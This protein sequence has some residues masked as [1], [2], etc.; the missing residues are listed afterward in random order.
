MRVFRQ[1]YTD[2][3]GKTRESSKWYVE[4]KD[5][6]ERLRRLP[7]FTDKAATVELGKRVERLV[8][9]RVMRDE[10][11]PELARWLETIPNDLRKRLGKIGL[12]DAKTIAGKKPLA[13]HVD[14]FVTSLRS[15]GLSDDYVDP[16][17]A[18]IRRLVELCGFQSI[19]DISGATVQIALAKLKVNGS[20]GT[21]KDDG[22]VKTSRGLGQRTLN[23]YLAATK[24]FTRW[25]VTEGRTLK[26]ALA[27]LKAGNANLDIRRERRELSETELQALLK[28]AVAG[29]TLFGIAGQNRR[30]LYL[31]A[32]ST[33][34]RASECA[35]LTPRHFDLNTDPP[36]VRIDAADEKSRRGDVLPIPSDLVTML[37]PWLATIGPNE[38]LWPGDWAQKRRGSKMMMADLARAGI[39]YRDDDGQQADFHALR[40]TFL[41]R[42]GRSGASP[43]A[44]QRLARHT[45]VQLTLGRYTHANL[46]DLQSAVNMLPPISTTSSHE[47]EVVTLQATGTDDIGQSVLQ[48][49]LPPGLPERDAKPFSLVHFPASS[50]EG[51]NG[52]DSTTLP[53]EIIEKTRQSPSFPDQSGSGWESNPPGVFSDA[54]LGLKPRAVTRAANTPEEIRGYC[55]G[56]HVAT[57]WT[58][59]L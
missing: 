8:G 32:V 12:L 23:H 20:A 5:A 30:R 43:K 47:S 26:N 44:M 42:L 45:T 11:S 37:R 56:S 55:F 54:T 53:C 3:A 35:S 38:P 7:G 9:F 52:T 14:D 22:T 1:R 36:T 21:K 15:A 24:Q 29:P 25:L 10:L 46:F 16:V 17:E 4:F 48:F 49:V 31:V 27:H 2:R 18:R 57:D 19:A 33:G 34:L 59:L 41:S 58:R 6:D 50:E 51:F 40:H 39:A 28:S 13:Q